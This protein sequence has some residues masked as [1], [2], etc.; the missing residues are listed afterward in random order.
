MRLASKETYSHKNLLL[1][2]VALACNSDTRG[3]EGERLPQFEF[4]L[5]YRDPVSKGQNEI[6]GSLLSKMAV[7]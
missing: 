7:S 1:A 3:T 6:H 2:L 4:F 5:G